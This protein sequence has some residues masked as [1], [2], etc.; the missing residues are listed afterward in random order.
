[1][2]LEKVVYTLVIF[3]K[4]LRSYFQVHIIAIL[5]NQSIRPILYRSDTS[6]WLAKWAIEL[7]EFDIKYLL[8]PSIKAQALVNFVL[9]CTILDEE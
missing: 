6:G 7:E 8:K 4:K 9:E 3:F 2:K 1:M 5:T